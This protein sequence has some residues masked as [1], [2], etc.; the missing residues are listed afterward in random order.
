MHSMLLLGQ[1]APSCVIQACQRWTSPAAADDTCRVPTSDKRTCRASPS[2]QQATSWK[3]QGINQTAPAKR[4]GC[5]LLKHPSCVLKCW[6]G[7]ASPA[8]AG[9]PTYVHVAGWQQQ[10]ESPKQHVLGV[11]YQTDSNSKRQGGIFPSY[12]SD[13]KNPILCCNPVMAGQ[14]PQLHAHPQPKLSTGHNC[15]ANSTKR[16]KAAPRWPATNQTAQ[17]QDNSCHRMT[18]TL[19]PLPLNNHSVGQRPVHLCQCIQA[20]PL[21]RG[22]DS[23]AANLHACQW[24]GSHFALENSKA[25]TCLSRLL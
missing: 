19:Q 11:S 3:G 17:W 25:H 12:C 15:K 8:V 20:P 13:F 4:G 21:Q 10:G 22:M 7:W 2:E 6:Q 18:L 1:Q 23:L 14:A 9:M 24:H 16:H 5:M